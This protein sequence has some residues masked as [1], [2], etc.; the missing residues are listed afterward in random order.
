MERAQ[1]I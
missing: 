1:T